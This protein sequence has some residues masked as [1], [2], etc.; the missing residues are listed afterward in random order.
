MTLGVVGPTYVVGDNMKARTMG[1]LTLAVTALAAVAPLQA[2][3]SRRGT[4]TE[5]NLDERVTMLT[6]RLELTE[7]QALSVREIIETQAGKHRGMS[8][9]GEGPAGRAERH[10]AMQ[11]IRAETMKRFGEV[12]SEEQF[13][14][15]Q[16]VQEETHLRKGSPPS[17]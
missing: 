12:L 4:G 9:A 5:P 2:Q 15:F 11:E 10:A 14:E 1:A 3:G 17:D 16:E 7:A 13:L 6:E 8:R